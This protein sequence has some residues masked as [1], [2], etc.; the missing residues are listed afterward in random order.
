M[1]KKYKQP[2]GKNDLFSLKIG[3]W[4]SKIQNFRLFSYLKEY[5]RKGHW[6]Q[7]RFKKSIFCRGR[8]FWGAVFW[9][10]LFFGAFFLK[11]SFWNEMITEL[12]LRFLG[13]LLNLT[14]GILAHN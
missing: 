11:Y 5:L 9:D 7:V 4:E 14:F 3:H 12:D 1:S 8:N 13:L 10:H 6:K 2:L